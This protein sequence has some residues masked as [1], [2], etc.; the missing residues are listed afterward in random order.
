MILD[1]LLLAAFVYVCPKSELRDL[2]SKIPSFFAIGWLI[3]DV[4]DYRS[5]R[6][7]VSINYRVTERF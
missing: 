6:S 1:P 7:D 5:K 4:R 3:K 2:F